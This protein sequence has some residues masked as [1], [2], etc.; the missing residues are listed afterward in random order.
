MI[1]KKRERSVASPPT[2]QPQNKHSARAGPSSSLMSNKSVSVGGICEMK[3][4][5]TGFPVEIEF[6]IQ[7]HYECIFFCYCYVCV[8]AT[9]GV[10]IKKRFQLNK[11]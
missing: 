9:S 11:Y 1:K 3:L 6:P 5:Q 7:T 8:F 2:R 4:Q 10:L